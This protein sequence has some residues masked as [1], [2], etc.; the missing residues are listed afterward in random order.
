MM[1]SVGY[2][3]Q[4]RVNKMREISKDD[5]TTATI[6][7]AVHFEWMI[8]RAIQFTSTSYWYLAIEG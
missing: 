5:P 8:K 1:F 2:G 4:N 6:L 7:A 3:I